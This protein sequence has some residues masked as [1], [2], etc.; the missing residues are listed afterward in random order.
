MGAKH[1]LNET[2]I[3]GSIALAGIIGGLAES[4]IAFFIAAAVLIGAAVYKGDVR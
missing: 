4:W 2:Y 1:K 3:V